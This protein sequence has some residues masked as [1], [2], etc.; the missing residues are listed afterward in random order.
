MVKSAYVDALDEIQRVMTAFLKPLGFRKSGRAYNRPAGDGLVHVVGFQMG[1]Y[2]IG[3]HVIPGIR[4][5][6]YGR[7]TVN[8]GIML[9]AVRDMEY[10]G[11][12]NGFA[13]EYHCEIRSRLG[14]LWFAGADVWWDLDYRI[15]ETGVAILE[16]MRKVGVPFL[17]RFPNYQSVLSTLEK[18]NELPSKNAGRSALVGALVCHKIGQSDEARMWFD[19]AIAY[20]AVLPRPNKGFEAHVAKLREKC[21]LQRL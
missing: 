17:D 9:P 14:S 8:L 15:A 12:S 21:G 5:S 20:A 2:P 19:R 7:F 13:Q 10:V 1:Q 4:E 3:Q 6:F 16:M 18:D 11:V